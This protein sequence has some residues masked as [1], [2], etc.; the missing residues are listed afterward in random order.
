[1]CNSPDAC[2]NNHD[3]C[4]L[5]VPCGNV[6][7]GDRIC[8][9]RPNAPIDITAVSYTPDSFEVRW[10][11]VDFLDPTYQPCVFRSWTVELSRRWY[12]HWAGNWEVKPECGN[13]DRRKG[14][15]RIT[16]LPHNASFYVRVKESCVDQALDGDFGVMPGYASVRPLPA[17]KPTNL[18]SLERQP[19]SLI[20]S[21]TPGVSED[22]VF[23]RW[24]LELRVDGEDRYMTVVNETRSPV[25]VPAFGLASATLYQVRV[26]E[27]CSDPFANS[28][29]A[30]FAVTTRPVP[31]SEPWNLYLQQAGNYSLY[32]GWYPGLPGDCIFKRWDV[33]VRPARTPTWLDADVCGEAIRWPSRCNITETFECHRDSTYVGFYDTCIPNVACPMSQVPD[34]HQCKLECSKRLPCRAI[35]FQ[36]A[37]LN[38][39]LIDSSYKRIGDDPV[40]QTTACKKAVGLFANTSYEM[41]VAERCTDYEGDGQYAPMLGLVNTTAS[42][43]T[44]PLEVSAQPLGPHVAQMTFTPGP[45]KDC[46][47]VR[48]VAD[49]FEVDDAV[50]CTFSHWG[51]QV[52]ANMSEEWVHHE[53]SCSDSTRAPTWCKVLGLAS[54]EFS[55]IQMREICTVPN[56]SSPFHV[57]PANLTTFVAA[58]AKPPQVLNVTATR[59]GENGT[60]FLAWDLG[61]LNDCPFIDWDVEVRLS[62]G[63][64]WEDAPS[65]ASA[66]VDQPACNISE[67]LASMSFYDIRIRAH[68]V[69][70]KAECD[71]LTVMNAVRT[72]PLRA[73]Q[74]I[75]TVFKPLEPSTLRLQ[76]VG[77]DMRDCAFISW[78]VLIQADSS[79]WMSDDACNT[80]DPLVGGCL[81]L[82]YPSRTNY[83]ICLKTSC[84]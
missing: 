70:P 57:P 33:Q 60:L 28:M 44:A 14:S 41:R 23:R 4:C 21:W 17:R 77:D 67:G 62:S 35:R 53:S 9:T 48:P 75:V 65:C 6:G 15:C 3:H 83:T 36:A 5:A 19:H 46:I 29:F 82:Q 73:V 52:K 25:R 10:R 24:Y 69:D 68:C 39:W 27:Q 32:M 38:C 16:G 12:A 43:A 66:G 26:Q 72:L 63:G 54:G 51:F 55:E 20:L 22:C 79:T 18:H 80:T 42:R 61:I 34:V 1:M 40:H 49:C 50:G 7:G 71:W 47:F 13:Q 31:A 58:Q 76:W 78:S 2:D 11:A 84:T 30:S 8:T 64:S 56:A 74:P 81:L 45:L 59:G 37:Y